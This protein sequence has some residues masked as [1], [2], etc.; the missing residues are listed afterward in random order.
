MPKIKLI[1]KRVYHEVNSN[2]VLILG[3]TLIGGFIGG[4]IVANKAFNV[5][6][7]ITDAQKAAMNLIVNG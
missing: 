4:A 5:G 3:A 7:A 6:Y 1:A 2:G